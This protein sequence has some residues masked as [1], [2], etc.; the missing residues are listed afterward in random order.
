M[1]IRVKS[2]LIFLFALFRVS[3]KILSFKFISPISQ[4][5]AQELMPSQIRSRIENLV[6]TYVILLLFHSYMAKKSS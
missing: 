3:V 4:L 5:L 2:Y 1:E 6:S